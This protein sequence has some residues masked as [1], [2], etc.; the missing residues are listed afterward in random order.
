MIATCAWGMLAPEDKGGWMR[1][2]WAK[3]TEL[4]SSKWQTNVAFLA[5]CD[6][7]ASQLLVQYPRIS[8]E[9]LLGIGVVCH[10]SDVQVLPYLVIR[11]V[12]SRKASLPST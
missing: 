6:K 1:G 5:S 8:V 12:T 7:L 3:K 10:R 4:D 9:W 11:P 2:L